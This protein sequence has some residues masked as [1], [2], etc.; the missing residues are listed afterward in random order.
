MRGAPIHGLLPM[1]ENAPRLAC[2]T[3]YI[4]EHPRWG[5]ETSIR[6]RNSG[7]IWDSNYSHK[8]N[9][10]RM[11]NKQSKPWLF[12]NKLS[13][14]RTHCHLPGYYRQKRVLALEL[15]SPLQARS[16]FEVMGSREH[17]SDACLQRSMGKE[18]HQSLR[19]TLSGIKNRGDE[20]GL[21]DT[22]F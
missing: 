2:K 12:L 17:K 1:D 18:D 16:K 9:A 7:H 14:S 22:K 21:A 19:L 8:L 13:W 3:A 20:K 4:S 10:R 6:E 5:R 11:W 15:P